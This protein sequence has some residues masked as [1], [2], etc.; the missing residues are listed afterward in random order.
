MGK[1]SR[2][3]G[4]NVLTQWIEDWRR[5]SFIERASDLGIIKQVKQKPRRQAEAA[6]GALMAEPIS[7]RGFDAHH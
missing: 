5:R 6:F 7:R 3:D 4:L 1:A 2:R